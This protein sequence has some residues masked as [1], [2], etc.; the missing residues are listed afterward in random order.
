MFSI[1]VVE[2]DKNLNRMICAKLKQ[3]QY[4]VFPAFDGQEALD[5][6]EQEHID[7]II[8][9]VM[10]PRMDGLELTAA[11]RGARMTLPILMITAKGQME[12]MEKGFRAGTDDYMVK[13]IQLRELL[14]RVEALLRRAQLMSEKRLNIQGTVLDYASLTVQTGDHTDTLPPKEFYL[15]FKLLNQPGTI[16]TRQELLDE[17][18][19]VD[20]DTDSRNV[21]AHIKKLR[22]RFGENPDFA[23]ETVRGLGYRAVFKEKSS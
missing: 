14:L 23:I 8:S 10:M 20:K 3:A 12:D 4:H 13:P 6:L 7:L 1:M 19:G 2:D 17:I 22:H 11:L 15:L 21:D 16:F 18:W 5:I 9:D